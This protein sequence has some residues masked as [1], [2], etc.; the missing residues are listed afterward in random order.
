MGRGGRRSGAGRPPGSATVKTR[1]LANAIADSQET[2]LE[3]IL[4]FMALAAKE[5][6]ADRAVR[7]ATVAAPYIHP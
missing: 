5:G 7:F 1:E 4:R 6:D 2:P 3:I